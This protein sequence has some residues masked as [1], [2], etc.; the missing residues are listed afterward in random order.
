MIVHH[1]LHTDISLNAQEAT[2]IVDAIATWLEHY[3]EVDGLEAKRS[4]MQKYLIDM[5]ERHED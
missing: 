3:K 5:G 4:R 2:D 1:E